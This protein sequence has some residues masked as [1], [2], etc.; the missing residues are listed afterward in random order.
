MIPKKSP[1]VG[2]DWDELRTSVLEHYSTVSRQDSRPLQL[3]EEWGTALDWG[4]VGTNALQSQ[5]ILWVKPMLLVTLTYPD[6]Q[7]PL[8]K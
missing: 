1:E 6:Q 3:A 8:I 5:T 4:L 7:S 2:Q